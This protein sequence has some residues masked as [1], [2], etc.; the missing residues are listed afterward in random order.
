MRTC[1]RAA[2]K[3]DMRKRKLAAHIGTSGWLHDGVAVCAEQ[4]ISL[5]HTA[6]F[7][8]DFSVIS[9][10]FGEPDILDKSRSRKS[11]GIKRSHSAKCAD[12]KCAHG[13]Y[14]G[15]VANLG[16]DNWS[17]EFGRECGRFDTQ[18]NHEHCGPHTDTCACLV[19]YYTF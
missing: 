15:C 9:V 4:Y 10:F 18:P 5:T 11:A 14:Y 17:S 19:T 1:S 7:E 8:S 3:H 6:N 2:R 13:S 16:C 12:L